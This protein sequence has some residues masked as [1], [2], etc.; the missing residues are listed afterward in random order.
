MREVL[1]KWKS[2]RTEIVFLSDKEIAH[3]VKQK[4]DMV[5]SINIIGTK[6]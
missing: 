2:G 1:L 5:P 3:I 4:G 6:R